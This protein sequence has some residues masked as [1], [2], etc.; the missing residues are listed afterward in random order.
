VVIAARTREIRERQMTRMGAATMLVSADNGYMKRIR[1]ALIGGL[2][3]ALLLAPPAVAAAAEQ[4]VDV[5]VTPARVQVYP[6][7]TARVQMVLTNTSP[8]EQVFALEILLVR[9]DG[10]IATAYLSD[11]LSMAPGISATA[12]YTIRHAEGS[13]EAIVTPRYWPELEPTPSQ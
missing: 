13:V 2:L 4:S 6:L 3:A 10:S 5:H 12:I 7:G 9:A 11:A 8:F 1:H